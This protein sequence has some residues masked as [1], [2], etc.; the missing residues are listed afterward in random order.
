MGRKPSRLLNRDIFFTA[1]EHLQLTQ[2]ALR[3]QSPLGAGEQFAADA[4]ELA[5]WPN[6]KL[7][8]KVP[9]VGRRDPDGRRG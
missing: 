2:R 1:S 8:R 7:R 6:L 4:V 9:T 3:R 5:T